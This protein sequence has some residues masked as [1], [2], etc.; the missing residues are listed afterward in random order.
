MNRRDAL[1]SLLTL[2][3]VGSVAVAQVKST[4]TIVITCPHEID[5]ETHARIKASAKRVFPDCEVVV[6]SDGTTLSI[7][8]GTSA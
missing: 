3:S 8:R 7:V 2:P 4:D 5:D 6:L 1:R